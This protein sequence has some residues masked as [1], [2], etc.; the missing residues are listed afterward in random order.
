MSIKLD[1]F[2]YDLIEQYYL[3]NLLESQL[4]L[5]GSYA[6]EEQR[7]FSTNTN[8]EA[9]DFL[10]RMLFGVKYQPNDFSFMLPIKI[11]QQSFVYTQFDDRKVIKDQ[12]FYIV[13]EPEIESGNY[14]IFKC[15]SNNNGSPSNEKPEFNPAIQNGIYSLSDGYI[16][17]YMSSTPFTLFRKFSARGLLPIIRNQQVENISSDGIFNVV[18]ENRNE[19]NGY[20][21]ITGNVDSISIENGITRVFLKNLFSETQSEIPIFEVANSY[22]N[23]SIYI[24]KSNLGAGIGAIELRIRDSGVLNNQPF[25][26]ISTPTGFSI[27]VNDIV[28]ILPRVLIQGTGSGATAIVVFDSSNKRIDSIRIIEYGSGYTNAIATIVDPVGFDPTNLNRED[29]RCLIR[30]IV[31]PVGG[32]GSNIFSELRS[33]HIGL[34]TTITSLGTSNIPSVGSYAKIGVVK[35]PEFTE[36]F[37]DATFDNRIKIELSIFTGNI[38]SVNIQV[39]NE[40]LQGN[41]SAVIH[42]IDAET[43]SIYVID[44]EGPYSEIFDENL[45]I[46]INGADFNINTIEYSAYKSRTGRVLTVSDVTPI[47]RDEERSEQIRLI[48]DF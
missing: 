8:R 14:H 36:S 27:E 42:E 24:E 30:P 34:S 6:N 26:T 2:D 33:K 15:I 29:I 46:R 43:N 18:V 19:N 32:H 12:P 35:N 39:G 9:V 13:V 11:W 17:K 20:E 41:I 44:Y 40:I 23:K 1:A 5:F 31:S 22:S 45:P 21:R 25:V 7:P 3:K 16:W 4:W 10:E 48:L 28:E 37:A 38:Q 47:E